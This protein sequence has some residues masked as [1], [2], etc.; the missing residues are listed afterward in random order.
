[1][2]T[3]GPN[4]TK[5]TSAIKILISET[6]KNTTQNGTNHALHYF[7]PAGLKVFQKSLE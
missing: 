5:K 7:T 4:F 6:P 1:M 2:K 3:D